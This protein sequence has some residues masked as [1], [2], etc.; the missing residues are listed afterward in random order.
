MGITAPGAE[1]IGNGEG[2]EGPTPGA[3][4]TVGTEG[5]PGDVVVGA[6]VNGT[7][8]FVRGSTP[9]VNGD[10]DAGI[11]TPGVATAATGDCSGGACLGDD[12]KRTKAI[13][14]SNPTTAM[15]RRG[16]TF[17]SL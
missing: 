2:A 14:A 6:G 4:G 17:T 9:G 1:G 8:V 3:V 13:A 15:A 10:G 12:V 7:V 11:V 16:C 5:N